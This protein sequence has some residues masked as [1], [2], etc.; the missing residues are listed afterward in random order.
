MRMNR[1]RRRGVLYG[2]SEKP[3]VVVVL[4]KSGTTMRQ[5]ATLLRWLRGL[6]P[7]ALLVISQTPIGPMDSAGVVTLSADTI[8]AGPLAVADAILKAR[9]GR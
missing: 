9:E 4:V 7:A 2:M 5:R 8:E 3:P 6:V 1:P